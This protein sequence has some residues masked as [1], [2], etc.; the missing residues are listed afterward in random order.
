MSLIAD[1][2]VFIA[3]AAVA[4]YRLKTIAEEKIKKKSETLTL[5]LV[6]N[7]DILQQVAALAQRPVCVGFAAETRNV[8]TFAMDKLKRK[9][10]DMICANNVS[11]SGIGFDADDNALM[12]LCSDG[13]KISLGKDSKLNIAYQL[14]K[15]IASRYCSSSVDV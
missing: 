11:Q 10:L 3:C 15:L 6:K 13:E 7:P 14:V 2:D 8:E 12:L 1:I 4:D 5:E 9:K